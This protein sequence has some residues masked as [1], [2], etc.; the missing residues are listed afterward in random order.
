MGIHVYIKFNI[1]IESIGKLWYRWNT[2]GNDVSVPDPPYN[3]CVA[4]EESIVLPSAAYATKTV[5]HYHAAPTCIW[6]RDP[7]FTPHTLVI[8]S[9]IASKL[10][11]SNK[12]Y[13]QQFFGIQ[14]S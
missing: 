4:H 2:N 1:G 13:L 12:S 14:L 8:S 6:I 5:A 7:T 9:S 3:V 10:I 11:D